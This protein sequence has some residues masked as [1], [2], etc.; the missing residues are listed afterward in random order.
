MPS[1]PVYVAAL[2]TEH[3]LIQA[4]TFSVTSEFM[5]RHQVQLFPLSDQHGGYI[6]DKM[7][8]ANIAHQW[9]NNS[10]QLECYNAD[11]MQK[12][13]R[14]L[15]KLEI[16]SSE[17]LQRALSQYPSERVE[18]DEL[19]LSRLTFSL[20][21]QKIPQKKTINQ[22]QKII[23]A[24][25][26]DY[27]FED[28]NTLSVEDAKFVLTAMLTQDLST[29]D[30]NRLANLHCKEYVELIHTIFSNE[31]SHLS[32]ADDGL[33]N[34]NPMNDANTEITNEAVH[35]EVRHIIENHLAAL[36]KSTYSAKI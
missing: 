13:L 15:A 12:N 20:F 1:N 4:L 5:P 28:V 31:M 14:T 26:L 6:K 7:T 16:I 24:S 9:V 3:S 30:Q 27:I 18:E 34:L 8:N 32:T 11:I 36:T 29:A 35:A 19:E 2:K 25:A 10:F 21:T 33:F 23:I 17:F 22:H